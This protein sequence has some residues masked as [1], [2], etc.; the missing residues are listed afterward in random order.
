MCRSINNTLQIYRWNPEVAGDKPRTQTYEVDLNDCGPMVLD[1]LIKIKNEMDSTLTFRRSCREGICGSCSMN[2]G[3]EN[4]LAC[5]WYWSLS[6]DSVIRAFSEIDKKTPS[7]KIYPLPHMYIVKD[8]VP[9]MN[10]FYQQYRSIKPWL[11]RK[12]KFVHG[13]KQLFQTIEERDKLVR[14]F[15]LH[16][17]HSF[18]GRTVRVH[19]VRVLQHGVP[20]VLVER[21]QV[22]RPG[23][24]H[25]GLPLDHRQSR[26]VR[27]GAARPDARRLLG[28]QVPHD[29]E[30][31]EDV[32]EAP[33][34]GQGHRRD[35][36]AAHRHEQQAQ[37]EDDARR[38]S[39]Q[40]AG[41]GVDL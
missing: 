27:D 6:A 4:T 5:I 15:E 40:E 34:P 30:L 21:R 19:P 38:R 18:A 11:Q 36:D 33:Q 28:F 22:P 41:D 29:H 20:V 13:E 8:L 12:D 39:T 17:I 14:H 3:G 9:D 24:A 2:I 23:R 16:F 10:L 35:Q 26:P 1:A 32:S 31:H 7:T 37:G 25:A